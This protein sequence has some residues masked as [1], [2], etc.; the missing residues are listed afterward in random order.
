MFSDNIII[1]LKN[2]RERK[3]RVFLTLLGIAIGI[4]A[5]VSLMSIGEGMEVAITQELSSLSD[6]ILVSIGINVEGAAPTGGGLDFSN[7]NYLTDRDI[8]GIQRVQGIKDISPILSS[9]GLIT[10]SYTHL[11]LPTN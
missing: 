2:I 1:A 6:T 7:M 3:T 9:S 5:I 8:G 11:T 10:V 4:M